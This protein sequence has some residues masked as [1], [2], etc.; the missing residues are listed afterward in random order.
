MEE[1]TE[2]SQPGV[3]AVS[4]SSG[5]AMPLVGFGTW[6]LKGSAAVTAVRTALDVG[7]RLLDTATMYRNDAEVGR[8]IHDSGIPRDQLFVTTKLQPGDAGREREVIQAS[9]SALGLEHVDL[10]LVH[11]PPSDRLLVRT[12]ERF[13]AI[14]DQG[15]ATAIGVSNY[16][17]EQIDRLIDATGVAPAVNQ[18]PWAPTLFDAGFLAASRDRNVV[19]EGYSPFKNTNLD[20]PTLVSI[21]RRHAVTTAQVVIRWHVQHEVVAIPKSASPDRMAQ[22]LA[23]LGFALSVAD[24]LAIDRLDR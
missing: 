1:V 11:W 20:D 4:L 14:R 9:L 21:A 10:W 2:R 16:S 5:T 3:P 22:N 12:W 8:A 19:V 15:L 6:G 17:I 7:Y 18:V 13:L 23:V 24:M